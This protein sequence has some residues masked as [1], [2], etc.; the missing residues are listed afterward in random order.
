[1]KWELNISA[2]YRNEKISDFN[3]K[4]F[5]NFC[6]T[7]WNIDLSADAFSTSFDRIQ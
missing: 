1:M 5:D 6:T 2:C 7:K 3:S 4:C